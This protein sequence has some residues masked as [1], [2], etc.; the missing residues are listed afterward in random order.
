MTQ[1]L[2][3]DAFL[4]ELGVCVALPAFNNPLNQLSRPYFIWRVKI[5]YICT[6]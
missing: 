4:E 2:C 1:A 6:P 5:P 3:A